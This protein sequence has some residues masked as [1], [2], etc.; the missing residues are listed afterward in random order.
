[1]AVLMER[2]ETESNVENIMYIAA[3]TCFQAD[4]GVTAP[5]TLKKKKSFEN[6][7]LN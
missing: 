3:F 1:M 4:F 5:S 6:T 2:L 7:K